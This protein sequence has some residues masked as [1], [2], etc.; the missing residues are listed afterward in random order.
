[1]I[2]KIKFKIQ[3][4]KMKLQNLF[5]LKTKQNNMINCKMTVGLISN[6]KLPTQI[7]KES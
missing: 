2:T 5:L 6:K 7:Y 1:M 3:L 4:I